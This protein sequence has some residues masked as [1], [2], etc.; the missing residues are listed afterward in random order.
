MNKIIGKK[1]G[2][3]AG[4]GF[5][6]SGVKREY[7]LI[8]LFFVSFL[9]YLPA[10]KAPFFWDDQALIPGLKNH[11]EIAGIKEE[12]RP[13]RALSLYIDHFL[14]RDNPAGYHFTN[15][16]LNSVAVIAVFFFA[17]FV[18]GDTAAAFLAAL[19]FAFHPVHTETVVWI[20]NRTELFSFIF[21]ISAFLLF[22]RN[23][24]FSVVLFILALLS[25]ETAASLPLI[26]SAYLLLF[27]RKLLKKTFPFWILAVIRFSITFAYATKLLGQGG[28][29]PDF[30]QH[31]WIILK[32]Y[33]FYLYQLLLPKNLCVEWRFKMPENFFNPEVLTPALTVLVF[34]LLIYFFRRRKNTL[35]LLLF[36][37]LSLIPQS[38][39]FYIAGRPWAEQRLY[40]P[41]A[42]FC[43]LVSILLCQTRKRIVMYGVSFIILFLYG[44]KTVSRSYE[45]RN[46]EKFWKKA[47]LN[48]PGSARLYLQLGN[49]Y[50]GK[51]EY[52]QAQD[53]YKK[54]ISL[55]MGFYEPYYNSGLVLMK[56]KDYKGAIPFFL[57]TLKAKP[58]SSFARYNLGIC[59]L[60]QKKYTQALEDFKK[61]KK[62]N[63]G[64]LKAY[65]NLGVVY[66]RMG[67]TEEA[68]AE[69]KEAIRLKPDYISARYNLAMVYKEGGDLSQA[70]NHLRIILKVNPH[71]Q[72]A[73]S[74]YQEIMDEK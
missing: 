33:H 58:D 27:N 59:H 37:F 71:N 15:I 41:S 21:Y 55:D 26:L 52:E 17:Q 57:Q 50:F 51:G 72:L 9:V 1:N 12:F 2:A 70:V 48:T 63:R 64:N 67:M 28:A 36:I 74:L 66:K 34:F 40:F 47:I 73:A 13:M 6:F 54:A 8:F 25:K 53:E 38:N 45:W 24:Y 23:Y 29:A 30:F 4:E 20:K 65:N 49:T 14:W 16:I 61:V 11:V 5:L 3:H 22:F 18:F 44:V 32:T 46:E 35:F 10:L 31:I 39:I 7:L 68:I 56:K 43:I 19:L 42:A 62:L 60:E 69:F